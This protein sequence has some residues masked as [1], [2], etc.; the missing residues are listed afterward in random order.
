MAQAQTRRR[1]TQTEAA[2]LYSEKPDAAMHIGGCSLYEG[3]L[4]RDALL[5]LIESRL[6]RLPQYRQKV[7][8]SPL[9]IAHPTWEDD[10]A[11]DLAHHIEEV[12]LPDPADDSVLSQV[13]GQLFA[14]PA[15][16]RDK[17]ARL[18]ASDT[19]QAIHRA[20]HERAATDERT[21]P[22]DLRRPRWGLGRLRANRLDQR[23]D[24]GALVVREV[25]VGSVNPERDPPRGRRQCVRV[26][27]TRT[28]QE[29]A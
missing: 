27:L 28:E 29:S 13:C 16:A 9:G 25:A 12:S 19:R 2:F 5:H 14:S 3:H 6:H 18:V 23:L 24:E 4:S 21:V 7:V 11:F 22:V 8:F 15:L 10:P 1:L 17:H 20:P 26:A